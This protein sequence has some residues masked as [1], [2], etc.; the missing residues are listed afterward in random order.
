M[1]KLSLI[2][3]SV[4]SMLYTGMQ[5]QDFT[6]ECPNCPKVAAI[7]EDISSGNFQYVAYEGL[8]GQYFG[9]FSQNLSVGSYDCYHLFQIMSEEMYK[10]TDC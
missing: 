9:A 8:T 2:L 4:F 1:K 7:N 3:F 5:A 10:A 6:F